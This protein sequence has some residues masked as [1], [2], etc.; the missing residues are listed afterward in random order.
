[1]KALEWMKAL[2]RDTHGQEGEIDEAI[3]ELEAFELFKSEHLRLEQ[4]LNQILHPNGDGPSAPS[5]CDLVSYVRADLKPKLCNTCTHDHCGC[6]IQDSILQ[7]E[8]D[9]TFDTFG[10][11]HHELSNVPTDD[12]ARI[13]Q[14]EQ[15]SKTISQELLTLRRKHQ[16]GIH[17]CKDAERSNGWSHCGDCK[18]WV[19]VY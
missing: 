14:L 11:M 13:N 5:F 19:L 10:C 12:M 3:V 2:R 15:M 1:M 6:S 16:I 4:E 17:C 18:N 9:A 8:P 7:V